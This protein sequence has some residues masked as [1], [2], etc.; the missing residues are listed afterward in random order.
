MSIQFGQTSPFRY[1]A[2]AGASP[3]PR[4]QGVVPITPR[5]LPV[6]KLLKTFDFR[7]LG[8]T[9]LVQAQ[10]IYTSCIL[11]RI[12]NGYKRS[13][14]D[15][16][17]NTIRD[18]LGWTAWFYGVP[19][20]QR[21][22]L[23]TFAPKPYRQALLPVAPKAFAEVLHPTLGQR[24]KQI[25]WACNPLVRLALPTLQQVK[26]QSTLAL[27]RLEDSGV[28]PHHAH[29]AELSNY[30]K[31]LV[32]WRNYATGVGYLTTIAVLGIGINCLNIMVT[33]HKVHQLKARQ[34]NAQAAE[35][36]PHPLAASPA[37][38]G[39]PRNAGF[40]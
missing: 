24:L 28:A 4:F 31:N 13:P 26:D 30:Y 39:F 38:S 25:N 11:S 6:G 3:S 18:S 9:T 2:Q 19:I 34:L 14:N 12:F 7:S 10:V 29:Y 40:L 27:A 36:K 20:L 35:N 22:F 21:V 37:A 32:K 17:E 33:R 16:R 5:Q 23:S 8:T 1:A 15:L